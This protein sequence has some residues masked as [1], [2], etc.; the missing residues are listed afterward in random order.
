MCRGPEAGSSTVLWESEKAI[1]I[2]GRL[3][4]WESARGRVCL[5]GP[6]PNFWLP[7]K[8]DGVCQSVLGW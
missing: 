4:R 7:P 8:S 1:V 5:P 3:S 6:R 2:G